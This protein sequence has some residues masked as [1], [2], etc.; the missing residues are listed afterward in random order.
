MI[1]LRKLYECGFIHYENSLYE[2]ME[3]P[4]IENGGL[5]SIKVANQYSG[6]L[7]GHNAPVLMNRQRQ[8]EE[9]LA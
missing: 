1:D 3:S 8:H 4:F 6:F 2:F 5:F 9:G 7:H